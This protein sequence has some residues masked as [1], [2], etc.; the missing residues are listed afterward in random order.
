MSFKLVFL[1][2]L[3]VVNGNYISAEPERRLLQEFETTDG[4]TYGTGL[5]QS[6]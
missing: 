4:G 5:P 3:L 6:V 1:A 2:L